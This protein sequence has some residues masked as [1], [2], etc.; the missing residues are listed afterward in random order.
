[1]QLPNRTQVHVQ[2]LSGLKYLHSLHKITTKLK[3][4]NCPHGISCYTG[5][6]WCV[7]SGTRRAAHHTCKH[8][9]PRSP[10]HSDTHTGGVL[11]VLQCGAP[12]ALNENMPVVGCI[13]CL[14]TRGKREKK[15][16]LIQDL[17]VASSWK[18][19]CEFQPSK[20]LAWHFPHQF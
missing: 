6:W 2:T 19:P 9:T 18:K 15:D 16:M 11:S 3:R 5:K 12:G 7:C 1:M 10:G 14:S 8:H 13:R 17:T 20:C 4:L